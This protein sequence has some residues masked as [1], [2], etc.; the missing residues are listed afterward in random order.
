MARKRRITS[1]DYRR[2]GR[3]M[4]AILELS[5]MVAED[6]PT[7]SMVLAVMGAALGAEHALRADEERALSEEHTVQESV[8]MRAEQVQP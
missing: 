2:A 5:R 6:L 4:R 1:A 8:L 3:T 7:H